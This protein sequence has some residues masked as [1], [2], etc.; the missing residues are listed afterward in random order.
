MPSSKRRRPQPVHEIALT[1]GRQR[2]VRVRTGY[3][4]KASGA[5]LKGID[6]PDE[7]KRLLEKSIQ[8]SGR[9]DIS[10]QDILVL[11][12]LHRSGATLNACCELLRRQARVR[13]VCVLTM[14]GTRTN[15]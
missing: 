14:T 5:E 12:D 11:D 6:D 13:K 1:S 9:E 10:G 3:L 8:I 7:R 4:S 15:R 2:Y